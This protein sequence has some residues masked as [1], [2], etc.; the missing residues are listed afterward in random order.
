MPHAPLPLNR[1][2]R[3]AFLRDGALVLTSASTLLSGSADACAAVEEVQS[4]DAVLRVVLM[5]D[6]HY[7][8]KPPAGTRHYRETPDKL[9]EAADQFAR[10]PPDLLIEL[11]DLIDAAE[12]VEV[13]QAYPT[14][15]RQVGY[16]KSRRHYVLGNHCVDMLTAEL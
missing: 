5:T 13:E 10:Q 9:A 15:N 14:I 6:L 12:E 2:S 7:A 4:S 8:D 1:A 16:F 3:R 11:G